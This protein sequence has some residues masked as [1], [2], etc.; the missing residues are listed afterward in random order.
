MFQGWGA[1]G[2]PAWLEQ[3]GAACGGEA[4]QLGRG[5]A[6]GRRAPQRTTASIPSVMQS[7]LRAPRE[8]RATQQLWRGGGSGEGAF[9]VQMLSRVLQG[10]CAGAE[11]LGGG[12]LRWE[13]QQK[14]ALQGGLNLTRESGV[15][16]SKTEE[17]REPVRE[18][19]GLLSGST[20]HPE[21][22]SLLAWSRNQSLG[23]PGLSLITLIC[24]VISGK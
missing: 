15:L 9:K 13:Q 2:R 18:Q 19:A 6:R 14:R 23:T 24:C 20:A 21:G 16:E 17:E 11:A 5:Q 22:A 12:K 1:A 4:E 10:T 8:Q 3:K 7:H